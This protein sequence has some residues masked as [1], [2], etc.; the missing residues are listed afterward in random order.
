MPTVTLPPGGS[1]VPVTASSPTGLVQY[2]PAILFTSGPI[3]VSTQG[4]TGPT[5]SVTSSANIT[6][7]NT[8]MQEVL[9]AAGLSSTCT[10]SEGGATG[11]TTITGGTLRTSEGTDLDSEA[12][13][14]VVTIPTNPAPDTEYT[15][16]IETVGDTYRYVF[17]EQIVNAD[18]SITVNAAHQYLLGPTALGELIIGQSVCV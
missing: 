15:G 11:S 8:S 16:S 4:T 1:A 10:A 3:T 7:V 18:G 17:N 6:T 14:T 2:G 9:T 5:G 12:D 13:D